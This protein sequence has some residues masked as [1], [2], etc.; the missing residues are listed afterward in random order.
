MPSS[1][2][3]PENFPSAFTVR[4]RRNAPILTWKRCY[5]LAAF[6]SGWKNSSFEMKGRFIDWT[7]IQDNHD[8]GRNSYIYICILYIYTRLRW[9]L[10]PPFMQVISGFISDCMA[11][12]ALRCWPKLVVQTSTL[13]SGSYWEVGSKMSSWTKMPS[14][15]FPLQYWMLGALNTCTTRFIML[16]TSN[17]I[18]QVWLKLIFENLTHVLFFLTKIKNSKEILVFSHFQTSS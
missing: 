14:L 7:K 13:K 8:L 17:F 9:D 16:K 1:M 12:L 10:P 6:Q 18:S 11:S 2:R 5:G 15:S 3:N 4:F